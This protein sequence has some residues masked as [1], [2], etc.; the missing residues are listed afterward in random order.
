M[1]YSIR[2]ILLSIATLFILGCNVNSQEKEKDRTAVIQVISAEEYKEGKSGEVLV[3]I[4]T[5]DEYNSG[6]LEG[7]VNINFF[8][9]NFLE[10]M[11]AY[12]KEQKLFLYCRSGGRSAKASAKLKNLGFTKIIDLKGGIKAWQKQGFEIVK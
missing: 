1:K 4:R 2:A 10:Q 12:D 6:H 3:D 11:S 8:D 5:P 7:A 9:K